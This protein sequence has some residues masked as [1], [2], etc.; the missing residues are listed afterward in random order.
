MCKL[1][2]VPLL[3]LCPAAGGCVSCSEMLCAFKAHLNPRDRVSLRG[4]WGKSAVLGVCCHQGAASRENRG[5]VRGEA[6]GGSRG[7]PRLPRGRPLTAPLIPSPRQPPPA[8]HNAPHHSG[9]DVP[10]GSVPPPP[11]AGGCRGRAGPAGQVSL[12]PSQAAAR[13][14]T[15]RKPLNL[16]GRRDLV[17]SSAHPG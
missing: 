9:S 17:A 10:R 4:L 15:S 3:S 1:R 7:L 14:V 12:C 5:R 11:A 13:P 8:G 2:P 16:S 6:W